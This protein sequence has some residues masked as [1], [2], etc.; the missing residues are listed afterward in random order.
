[1]GNVVGNQ[2]ININGEKKSYKHT[3]LLNN[4]KFQ[5]ATEI[6]EGNMNCKI[7]KSIYPT[8]T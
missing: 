4:I 7:S 2:G 1:M 5:T 8:L 3:Q 6:F